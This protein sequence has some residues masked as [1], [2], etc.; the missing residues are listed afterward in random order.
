MCM[1]HA[2][3]HVKNQ[4]AMEDHVT[5]RSRAK[6]FAWTPRLRRR[7]R[8]LRRQRS[9]KRGRRTSDRSNLCDPL[10]TINHEIGH[11]FDWIIFNGLYF[12][13]PRVDCK[14]HDGQ[15]CIHLPDRESGNQSDA[16]I[17][18]ELQTLSRGRPAMTI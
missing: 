17:R 15:F 14:G 11:A 16:K 12:G 9:A 13:E 6:Y 3:L 5:Y 1:L 4:K 18:C 8:H 10:V 7:R 2:R